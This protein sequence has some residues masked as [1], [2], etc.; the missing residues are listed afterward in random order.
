MDDP[1]ESLCNMIEKID[2]LDEREL[3]TLFVGADVSEEDRMRMT[4][5]IEDRFDE[6]ELQVYIGGQEIYDYLISVE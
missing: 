6:L 3:I 4:E 1:V 2:D 5:E